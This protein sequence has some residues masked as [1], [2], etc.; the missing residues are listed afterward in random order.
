VH[1]ATRLF[2]TYGDLIAVRVVH[3]HA[4]CGNDLTMLSSPLF[5][6]ID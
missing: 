2:S 4:A 3:L 6:T 1:D 5:D